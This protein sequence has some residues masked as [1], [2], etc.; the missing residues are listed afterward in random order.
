MSEPHPHQLGE[1]AAP[2]PEFDAAF[3][4]RLLALFRWRRDVRRFRRDPIDEATLE[5]LVAFAS[6]A[7]SVGY[8]QPWRFVLVSDEGRRAAV[9]DSYRR[10]N[11]A[12]LADF[13]GERAALYARLK[14]AGL[15]DAPVQ[16]AVF[17]DHATAAGHGVGRKTMPQTLRD[18]VVTAVHGLWL[19]ARAEGIGV[20]WVSILEPDIVSAALDVPAGWELVAYL[21]IGYPE[22]ESP[23]PELQR[24][25]WQERDPAAHRLLRR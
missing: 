21:C 19:A 23:E 2:A 11:A 15:D 18:S 9:R 1:G 8:S 6:L 24:V 3:R 7:P 16:L 25:G 17:V 12:A 22:E 10:C 20:G 13:S 5:R 4:D 14:L